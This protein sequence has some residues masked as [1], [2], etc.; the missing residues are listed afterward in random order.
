MRKVILIIFITLFVFVEKSHSRRD[1]FSQQQHDSIKIGEWVNEFFFFRREK[2]FQTFFSSI[3]VFNLFFE[4]RHAALIFFFRW[5]R[6]FPCAHMCVIHSGFLFNFNRT[7]SSLQ[8]AFL[9]I[10]KN[11]NLFSN[12]LCGRLTMSKCS[13]LAWDIL[14][15]VMFERNDEMGVGTLEYYLNII[16]F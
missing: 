5:R 7:L 16:L 11:L 13:T 15:G 4:L 8:V 12:M 3:F 1:S 2:C 14:M 6:K 10:Y 9:M